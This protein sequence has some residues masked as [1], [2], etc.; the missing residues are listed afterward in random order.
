MS[1]CSGEILDTADMHDRRRVGKIE[2]YE[3]VE[4]N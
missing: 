4:T 2:M 3:V 1:A